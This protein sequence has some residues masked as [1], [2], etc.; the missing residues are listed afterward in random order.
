[1]P[2][3]SP[4]KNDTIDVWIDSGSSHRAVAKT[5]PAIQFPADMYL[6][7]SD[8]HRGWF[9]SSLLLSVATTGRAPYKEVLT[10]GFVVDLDGKKL[11]KSGSG[12]QKPIDMM[13]MINQYGADILRLWVASENYQN[14]VPW[15]EEIFKHVSGSYRTI[16]N[17]LRILHANLFDF[18]PG[19]D[20]VDFRTAQFAPD[21]A[22]F[23]ALDRHILSKL[24]GLI[25]ECRRAYGEYEFHK[26]YHLI[27]AFCTVELSSLY[28]DITKDRMYCDIPHSPP[29]PRHPDGHAR[30]TQGPHAVDRADHALHIGRNVVIHHPRQQCASPA[31]P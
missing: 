6:E 19:R 15:S 3:L 16:R 20:A 13:S 9:Q 24:Q 23:I 7:G 11:S 1:M 5:H 8:Q 17:T 2:T 12:Y 30:D 4:K 29:P 25:A 28:V 22:P 14:D 26:V 18:D 10:N 27:N 21:S 31:F